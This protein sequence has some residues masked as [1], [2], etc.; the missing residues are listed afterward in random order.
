M[1]FEG[2]IAIINR[3]SGI[4]NQVINSW[5]RREGEG[6]TRDTR[7][8]P[9]LPGRLPQAAETLPVPIPTPEPS[10]PQAG[11]TAC[12]RTLPSTP[13]ETKWGLKDQEPIS[14][15]LCPSKTPTCSS[16]LPGISGTYGDLHLQTLPSHLG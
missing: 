15:Y 16:H 14:F 8:L 11:D 6:G 5:T 2:I 7:L 3:R 12:S 10:E 13:R 4:Y 9:Q 1:N